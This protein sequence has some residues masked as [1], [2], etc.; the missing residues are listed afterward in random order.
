MKK[1]LNRYLDE[2]CARYNSRQISEAERFETF[3]H[4][5]E[6]RLSWKELTDDKKIA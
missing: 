6:H 2:F 4:Q 3:L 1:H 5:S